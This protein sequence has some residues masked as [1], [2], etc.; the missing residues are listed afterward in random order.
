MA[1][2]QPT[3]SGDVEG[4]APVAS[5]DYTELLRVSLKQQKLLYISDIILEVEEVPLDDLLEWTRANISELLDE[6]HNNDD[7]NHKIK[8]SHR[9]KFAKTVIEIG[10][11]KKQSISNNNIP[12]APS[13]SKMKLLIIGKEEEECIEAIQCGQQYM[14]T[15]MIKIKEL[16]NNEK[17]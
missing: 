7:N 1:A 12:A 10:K 17:K 14:N 9:N 15:A 3:S 8:V 5:I 16:Y 2:I 6:I 4:S 11:S 13:S